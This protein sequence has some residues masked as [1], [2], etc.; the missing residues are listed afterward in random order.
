MLAN[1]HLDWMDPTRSD[2]K[3][4]WTKVR[5]PDFVNLLLRLLPAHPKIW[6][7]LSKLC[8]ILKKHF[9]QEQMTIELVGLITSHLRNIDLNSVDLTSFLKFSCK[10]L[11]ADHSE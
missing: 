2:I 1:S 10:T 7:V 6:R 11:F 8:K 5:D 3:K 9:A 4:L